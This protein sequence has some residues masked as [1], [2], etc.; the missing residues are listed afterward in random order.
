MVMK[1]G[2][3]IL[4]EGD[5]DKEFLKLY[6]KYLNIEILDN[7]IKITNGKNDI[8]RVSQIIKGEW[9]IIFD[10]DDD[11]EVAKENIKDQL[12]ELN[13]SLDNIKIFLFPNNKDSGNL[14]TILENIAIHKEI[15]TCFD[16][17]ECCLSKNMIG[18]KS[19]KLPPKK[20][21]VFAYMSSFGFKNGIKKEEFDFSAYVDFNSVCLSDLKTFLQNALGENK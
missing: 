12:K 17:Y 21:K 6:L 16:C 8:K 1:S 2:I 5:T 3:N 13:V 20:S 18:D 4:V 11:I 7:Q 15:L 10:A 9:L 14:E 19:F